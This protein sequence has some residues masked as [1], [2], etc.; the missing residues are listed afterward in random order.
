MDIA[1]QYIGTAIQN[2]GTFITYCQKHLAPQWQPNSGSCPETPR[3]HIA[4][5]HGRR[6]EGPFSAPVTTS[7]LPA[8]CRISWRAM[9]THETRVWELC[10]IPSHLY[11]TYNKGYKPLQIQIKLCLQLGIEFMKWKHYIFHYFIKKHILFLYMC[12]KNKLT[13]RSFV[14]TLH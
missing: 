10:F 14:V 11:I 3:C 7:F 9:G 1:F 5:I 8:R 13:V 12:H 4:V 2:I 6:Q